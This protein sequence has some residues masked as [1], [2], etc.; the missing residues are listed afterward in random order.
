MVGAGND[1]WEEGVADLRVMV[2][3]VECQRD[4]DTRD[5]G[6]L[7]FDPKLMSG[8]PSC[9]LWLNTAGVEGAN[10]FG[11]GVVVKVASVVVGGAAEIFAHVR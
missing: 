9:G 8:C 7:A 5:L 10:W 2:V 11:L 4:C 3:V 6:C 1:D